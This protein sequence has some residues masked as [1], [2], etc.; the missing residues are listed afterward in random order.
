MRKYQDSI[1]KAS[2]IVT[3]YYEGDGDQSLSQLLCNLLRIEMAHGKKKSLSVNELIKWMKEDCNRVAT[4][5]EILYEV[6]LNGNKLG[7]LSNGN[8]ATFSTEIFR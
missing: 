1:D 8:I 6:D 7:V 5:E 2:S 4:K 3:R